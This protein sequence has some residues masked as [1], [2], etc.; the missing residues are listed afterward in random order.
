VLRYYWQLLLKLPATLLAAGSTWLTI[1]GLGVALLGAI[2]LVSGDPSVS[3]WLILGGVIVLIIGGLG[4]ANWEQ[5][6][7]VKQKANRTDQS[8]ELARLLRGQLQDCEKRYQASQAQYE[9]FKQ[10]DQEQRRG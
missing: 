9:V 8:E 3:P 4:R 1:V 6:D 7:E 5:Y 10:W 2:G